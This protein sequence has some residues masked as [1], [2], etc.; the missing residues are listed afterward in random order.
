M[1]IGGM[2]V[3]VLVPSL[4]AGTMDCLPA[5]PVFLRPK[6]SFLLGATCWACPER[7]FDLTE[8]ATKLPRRAQRYTV[9]M[10]GEYPQ[11]V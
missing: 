8:F 11:T 10:C 7:H 6:F 5:P 9:V 4:A 3:I 2:Q 1:Q